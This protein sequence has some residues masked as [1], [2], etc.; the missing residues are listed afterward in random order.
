MTTAT[1][2]FPHLPYIDAVTAALDEAGLVPAHVE[3][4]VTEM[5]E[6]TATLTWPATHPAVDATVLPLGIRLTW[7]HVTG[8]WAS[9]PHADDSL[10]LPLP[11]ACDPAEVAAAVREACTAGLFDSGKPVDQY[12]TTAL[13]RHQRVLDRGLS[14]WEERS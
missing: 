3:A 4:G 13:W 2:V 6:L 8:W 1:V 14:D 9:D 10:H 12:G 11:H 7:R 5:R